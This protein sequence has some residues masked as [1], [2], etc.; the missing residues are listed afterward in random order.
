MHGPIGLEA[1]GLKPVGHVHWNQEWEE[2]YE[3]ALKR[4]E[5]VLSAHNVLVAETGERTG[6][7][8]NDKFIV[9]EGESA[10]H[11]W[12]GDVNV[13]TSTSI[14]NNL[15][16]KVKNYLN[17]RNQLFVQ[18]LHC[19]ADPHERL[20]IRLVTENAWHANFARNMF[21][22]PSIAEI[23]KHIPE[24]TI[25][26]APHFLA[27]P[28]SDNVNSEAFVMVSFEQK[29]VLIGGTR[30]AGEIKKSIFSIMN[31]LLPIKGQLPMHCSSN[32]TGENTAVF[33]GL[34][35]TGKTT[36]SADPKRA[37]VGDDEHGWSNDGVFN[38]EGGCYAKLIDLSEEDEPAIFATT[39]M[40]GS[41]LENIVLNENGIPDFEDGSKTANTR[42]S[43]P[44]EFISN[45]TENSMAG[46]PQNVVFLTCDAF[47]VL[48]PISKLNPEQA[49]YHFISGYT[50]KVAGTEVGV[51]EPQATF[52]ACFGA[53]FMPM[54][55]SVYAN[56]LAGKMSEH[57]AKCWLLNTGW[58]NGG[59]GKSK[60][61]KIRWTRALLNAALDGTLNDVEFL[62][63]SRFGFEIPQSCPNVPSEILNPR[64]TW[65]D[66][67][68]FDATADKLANMFNENFVQF[69][70]GTGEGVLS[71]AP[72]ALN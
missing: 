48:P 4:D 57:G 63:D 66:P 18:D 67:S 25:L 35:G 53:P 24:F 56:L 55:P 1:H 5:V 62:T 40:P 9:K 16:E 17:K 11:I 14:F 26:H 68:A 33:F 65:S 21:L 60:R 19:G 32:T 15:R 13:P 58:V 8:P 61:I 31:Y 43:Y 38:F 41:I 6:R 49:A 23:E 22:R 52:S 7:S 20:A 44:I 70:K 28:V 45:R 72:K 29:L 51:K 3:I 42:G 46:H 69:A 54:H 10:E 50:A 34:S 37:L 71:S 2:L 64:D 39:K 59:Y 27:D 36:L 47:G 30:Y 12:W